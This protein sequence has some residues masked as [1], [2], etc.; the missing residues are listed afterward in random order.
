[1]AGPL[2]VGFPTSREFAPLRVAFAGTPEFAATPQAA[3]HAAL[4]GYRQA[5]GAAGASTSG[6]CR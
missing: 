6:E 2:R 5:G 4:F 3:L 1:M